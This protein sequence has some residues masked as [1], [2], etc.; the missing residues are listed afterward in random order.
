M[1]IVYIKYKICKGYNIVKEIYVDF[2]NN[3]LNSTSS[4]AADMKEE[5]THRKYKSCYILNR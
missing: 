5:A 4:P 3:P 1:Y 2:E